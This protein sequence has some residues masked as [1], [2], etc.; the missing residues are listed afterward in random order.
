MPAE[1]PALIAMGV[2][3]LFEKLDV[4]RGK[5]TVIVCMG[6]ILKGDD[7]AGPLVFQQLKGKV[8]ADLIDAG[9]V[10]ENYIQMIIK[11]SPQNL[12]IIDAV[13]FAAPAGTINIFRPEQLA[14]LVVSTHTLSPR[15]FID[16]V[17]RS[18]KVD[19]YFIG[20]QPAQTQFNAPVSSEVQKAVQRLVNILTA[21]FF[22][23]SKT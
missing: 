13:D 1:Y 17:C 8:R 14:N 5:K 23:E 19:V 22:Q 10:P 16:C 7:G 11:K 3:E 2:D 18:I 15:L 21:I 9:T 6:N 20:I 12:I 4:L